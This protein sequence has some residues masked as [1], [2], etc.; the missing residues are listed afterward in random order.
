MTTVSGMKIVL[1][2]NSERNNPYLNLDISARRN[3]VVGRTTWGIMFEVFNALNSDDLTI[4]SVQPVQ[5]QGFDAGSLSV[6]SSPTQLDA[7]R[8]F[9]RRFQVGFQVQF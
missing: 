2:R 6:L 9:G 5:V 3:F 8:R 1:S 7:T 4:T